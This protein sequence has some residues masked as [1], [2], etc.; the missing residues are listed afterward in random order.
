MGANRFNDIKEEVAGLCT[1]IMQ[2]VEM[3]AG[4]WSFVMVAGLIHDIPSVKDL[5][6]RIMLAANGIIRQRLSCMANS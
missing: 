4:V 6:D 1:R 3:K 2:Q 5:I